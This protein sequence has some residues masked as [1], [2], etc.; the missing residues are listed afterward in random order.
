[1]SS[2][3]W[4]SPNKSIFALK[5]PDNAH[6]YE[7]ILGASGPIGAW[8]SLGGL[9]EEAKR[10]DLFYWL[11]DDVCIHDGKLLDRQAPVSPPSTNAQSPS[12]DRALTRLGS[13]NCNWP[14]DS[15]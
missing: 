8:E 3:V 9:A 12:S 2:S 11:F 13:L 6:A 1:M 4:A 10:S 5:S 14:P 7:R 15:H